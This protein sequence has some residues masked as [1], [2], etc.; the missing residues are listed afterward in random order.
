MVNTEKH[1][2]IRDLTATL[3]PT[4]N[5]VLL[6]S[7]ADHIELT[8]NKESENNPYLQTGNNNFKRPPTQNLDVL[9]VKKAKKLFVRFCFESEQVGTD[10]R[11]FIMFYDEND[12]IGSESI[13]F[14]A[15]EKIT[16]AEKEVDV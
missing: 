14:K 6:E 2:V 1:P 12:R 9:D 4:N 13:L 7:S 3:K 16:Y 11:L 10:Y 15:K 8:S 5:A